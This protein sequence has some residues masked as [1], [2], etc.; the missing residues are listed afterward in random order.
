M[1]AGDRRI[2]RSRQR[3][4][5]THDPCSR[6]RSAPTDEVAPIRFGPAVSPRLAAELTGAPLDPAAIARAVVDAQDA[7]Q[8]AD[9]DP[10]VIEGVRGLL[11][12]FVDAHAVR[13]LARELAPPVVVVARPGR[14]TINPTLLTSMLGGDERAAA[15]TLSAMVGAVM[16]ARAL[17]STDRSDE[18]LRQ[19]RDAVAE[20]RVAPA[21]AD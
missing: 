4:L 15:V 20:R 2:V 10:L 8:R 18:I 17:G 19:V 1:I 16:I 21:S 13:D 6:R 5:L 12:P 11:V 14:G 7:A 9:A 3:R